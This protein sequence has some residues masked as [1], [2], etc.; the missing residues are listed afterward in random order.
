MRAAD[1]FGAISLVTFI[2]G[3]AGWAAVLSSL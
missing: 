3:I 2:A 1:L